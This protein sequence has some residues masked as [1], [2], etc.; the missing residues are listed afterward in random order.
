M[1][2]ISGQQIEEASDQIVCNKHENFTHDP[3]LLYR[4]LIVSKVIP[5]FPNIVKRAVK[6]I[7]ILDILQKNS[8]HISAMLELSFANCVDFRYTFGVLNVL[9]DQE[10]KVVIDMVNIYMLDYHFT[11]NEMIFGCRAARRQ[12]IK[13]KLFKKRYARKRLQAGKLLQF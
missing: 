10:I 6:P 8:I 4:L 1:T 2:S 3:A 7:I 5:N 13:A 9:A 11:G 12:A